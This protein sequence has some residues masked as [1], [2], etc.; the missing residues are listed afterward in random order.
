LKRNEIVDELREVGK[1]LRSF[2]AARDA[3]QK[4]INELEG[5]LRQG[6]FM[7]W[8]ATQVV[9]NGL[10]LATVRCEGLIEDYRELLEKADTPNNVI[11]LV[12]R[13]ES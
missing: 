12:E 5:T 4:R 8:A 6:T 2:V 11:E 1:D 10:I 3:I 9:L 13:T 7:N